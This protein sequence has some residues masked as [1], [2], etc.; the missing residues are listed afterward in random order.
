MEGFLASE[1]LYPSIMS[2]INDFHKRFG[3]PI[4]IEEARKRFVARVSNDIFD[5]WRSGFTQY[6]YVAKL[7][8]VLTILGKKYEYPNNSIYYYVSTE[9]F[10]EVLRAV[11]AIYR[12]RTR[13]TQKIYDEYLTEIINQPEADIGIVWKD[14]RFFPTGAESLDNELLNDPLKWL[15]DRGYSTVTDPFEKARHHFLEAESQPKVLSDVITDAYEALE[16][17]TK[18]VL[19]NNQDL[20]KNREKFVSKIK[21]KEFHKKILK[22]YV[23]YG[24]KYRHAADPKAPRP[25]PT[26]AEAEFFLYFTGTFLRL[27][28][29]NW[30]GS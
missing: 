22:E 5:N 9:N 1:I 19:D 30:K 13:E 2:A 3:I 20:S 25:Q 11:E 21:G 24:C 23:D 26:I 17:L 4:S 10:E 27:A 6:Q 14:G 8:N 28:M 12:I 16:A 7:K 18:I 15:R 29:E